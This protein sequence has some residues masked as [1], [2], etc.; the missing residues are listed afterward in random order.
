MPLCAV[1]SA[2]PDVYEEKVLLMCPLQL[3]ALAAAS[4][5]FCG[6]DLEGLRTRSPSDALWLTFSS[7]HMPRVSEV[8][9]RPSI[10]AEPEQ[11]FDLQYTSFFGI[12]KTAVCLKSYPKPNWKSVARTSIYQN[13]TPSISIKIK[14]LRFCCQ[15][16]VG[17]A[18]LFL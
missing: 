18:N 4:F 6:R 17:Y 3:I 2:P 7:V 12:Q 10:T 5:V 8:I 14:T 16:W 13:Y 15:P 9:R 1:L 11:Y